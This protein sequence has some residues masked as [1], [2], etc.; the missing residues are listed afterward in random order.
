MIY[1]EKIGICT[2]IKTI[3]RDKVKIMRVRERKLS[4]KLSPNKYPN[5]ISQSK[6]HIDH[7]FFQ[8]THHINKIS[9]LHDLCSEQPL[10]FYNHDFFV[11]S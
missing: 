6:Y 7:F 5:I 10:V 11:Y 1:K 4:L 3:K 8:P 2:E 9:H